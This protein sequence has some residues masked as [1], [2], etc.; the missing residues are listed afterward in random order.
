MRRGDIVIVGDV[1]VTPSSKPT[2]LAIDGALMHPLS[3]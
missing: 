2:L 1:R 3:S